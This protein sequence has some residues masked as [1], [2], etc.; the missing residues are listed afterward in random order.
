MSILDKITV[1]TARQL[2]CPWYHR[3][4]GHTVFGLCVCVL[5]CV[6]QT[7]KLEMTSEILDLEL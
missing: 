6:K 5:M 7:L 3:S 4:V 2:L 1:R